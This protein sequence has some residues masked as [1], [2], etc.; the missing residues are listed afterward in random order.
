MPK[1]KPKEQEIRPII[2][3]ILAILVEHS[4]P[5]LNLLLTRLQVDPRQ[6]VI[7]SSTELLHVHYV[8][9]PANI[10]ISHMSTLQTHFSVGFG[11]ISESVSCHITLLNRIFVQNSLQGLLNLSVWPNRETPD[12]RWGYF[13]ICQ[14]STS[15]RKASWHA[16]LGLP[17][18]PYI[19]KK[20]ILSTITNKPAVWMRF[21]WSMFMIYVINV[22][23]YCYR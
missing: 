23:K 18:N 9:P 2:N 22:Y 8:F 16:N 15:I 7:D 4:K 3:P 21:M 6:E 19:W 1:V 12:T 11:I 17:L 5:S 13:L 14:F 20:C 10:Q